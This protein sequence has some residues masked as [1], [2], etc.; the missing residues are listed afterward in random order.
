VVRWLVGF[1]LSVVVAAGVSS[2]ASGAA[3][4]FP[5]GSQIAFTYGGDLFTIR[6]DGG[7]L[8]L[9]TVDAHDPRFSP[10][11]RTIAYSAGNQVDGWE[12]R[13]LAVDRGGLSAH[14]TRSSLHGHGRGDSQPEWFPS[15]KRLLFLRNVLSARAD[16]IWAIDVTGHGG[17]RLLKPQDRLGI[18]QAQ[19]SRNGKDIVFY[20]ATGQLWAARADGTDRHTIDAP[21]TALLQGQWSPDGTRLAFIDGVDGKLKIR[22]TRTHRT[23]PV[24]LPAG[25]A[26]YAWSPTGRWLAVG[27]AST[28]SC[29]D[30]TNDDLCPA[31]DIWIVNTDDGR[32]HRIYRNTTGSNDIT[33]IDWSPAVNS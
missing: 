17:R 29:N 5:S 28:Y 23:H 12:I 6:S 26:S 31:A 11:G 3:D 22:D 27:A 25:V 21:R 14:L 33:A 4:G 2:A 16:G 1:G 13:L 18:G 10:D 8:R 32:R 9:R 15:G 20:D 24:A 7:E 19:V 30:P